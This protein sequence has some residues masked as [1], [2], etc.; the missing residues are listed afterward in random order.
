VQ[1][2]V[3]HLAPRITVV[4]YFAILIS[5]FSVTNEI[6]RPETGFLYFEYVLTKNAN[7]TS[8]V[9]F[10]NFQPTRMYFY[11]LNY[12]WD[13]GF[14]STS[15]ENAK[16]IQKILTCMQYAFTYFNSYGAS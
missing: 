5:Y 2:N 8:P 16:A 4:C 13:I 3:Q 7:K 10:W 11:R 14:L 15:Y 1:I 12:H 9:I 6:F